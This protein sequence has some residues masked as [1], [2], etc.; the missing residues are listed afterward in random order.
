MTDRLVN[1]KCPSNKPKKEYNIIISGAIMDT[2]W[3]FLRGSQLVEII[4]YIYKESEQEWPIDPDE[5]YQYFPICID[6]GKIYY[7]SDQYHDICDLEKGNEFELVRVPV[8]NE[9]KSSDTQ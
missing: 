7:E 5:N 6:T 4:R 9:Q 3:R 1:V 2:E 8:K